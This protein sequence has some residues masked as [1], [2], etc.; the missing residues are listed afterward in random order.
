MNRKYLRLGKSTISILL[1]VI[2]VL[3]TVF[4]GSSVTI[5]TQDSAALNEVQASGL[6]GFENIRIKGSGVKSLDGTGG[7]WEEHALTYD[8]TNSLFYTKV[9]MT[10][11]EQFGVMIGNSYYGRS[12]YTA[13]ANNQKFTISTGSGMNI[14]FGSPTGVYGV[15]VTDSYQL[16][17]FY[18]GDDV[19]DQTFGVGSTNF[20][21][22]ESK[23]TSSG[24]NT[25][26]S[27][28]FEAVS[29]TDCKVDAYIENGAKFKLYAPKSDGTL[30]AGCYNS[31]NYN[32]INIS[33]DTNYSFDSYEAGYGVFQGNSG[34]YTV[35]YN[36]KNYNLYITSATPY[37]ITKNATG[38]GTVSVDSTAYRHK[39]VT[40]TST[41]TNSEYAA[42]VTVNK[43]GDANT[44][45][46]STTTESGGVYTTTFEMPAYAVTVNVTFVEPEKHDL[47]LSK[48]GSGT[49]TG[50]P[51]VSQTEGTAITVTSTPSDSSQIAVVEVYK[52]GDSTTKVAATTKKRS[53]SY[54][55]KFNMPAYDVTVSVTFKT[56]A[57]YTVT[58]TSSNASVGTATPDTSTVTEGNSIVLTASVTNL[59][60][61]FSGWTTTASASDYTIVSGS[62]SNSS[63][64]ILTIIPKKTV[65]FKANFDQKG[66]NSTS[67]K[68]KYGDQSVDNYSNFNHEVDVVSDGSV[69]YCTIDTTSFSRNANY[70]FALTKK[71]N[72]STPIRLKS[73]GGVTTVTEGSGLSATQKEI[74]IGDPAYV[75]AGCSFAS[76]VTS[77]MITVATDGGWYKFTSNTGSSTTPT[78]GE[79]EV[80]VIAK[81]GTVRSGFEKFVQMADTTILSADSDAVYTWREYSDRATSAYIAKD[82]EV[83]VQTTISG[84][85]TMSVKPNA[86]ASAQNVQYRNLYYVKAFVAN[87]VTYPATETSSGS[88]I[89]TATIQL[90]DDGKD[91]E[92][93][94]VY[95]YKKFDENFDILRFEVESFNDAKAAWGDTIACYVYYHNNLSANDSLAFDNV[96][97]PTMGGFPGQPMVYENGTY[98][99]EFPRYD[100]KGHI[101]AGMTLNNYDWDEVN[102]YVNGYN[103]VSKQEEANHQTYD[104]DDF[105]ILAQDTNVDTIYFRFKYRTAVYQNDSNNDKFD[106]SGGY[107]KGSSGKN[108]ADITANEGYANGWEVYRDHD[109]NIVDIFNNKLSVTSVTDGNCFYAVS[110]GYVN[111]GYIGNFATEWSI[112]DKNGNFV[113][114]LAPSV[115]FY[116]FTKNSN[117]TYNVANHTGKAPSSM[118]SDFPGTSSDNYWT[119]Y[120]TLFESGAIG[121]PLKITFESAIYA[122]STVNTDPAERCDGRWFAS[123][124]NDTVQSSIRIE[125]RDSASSSTWT[126]DTLTLVS[127]NTY[128]GSTTKADVAFSDSTLTSTL[129]SDIATTSAYTRSSSTDLGFTADTMGDIIDVNYVYKFDGFYRLIDGKYTKL[130][131]TSASGTETGSVDRLTGYNIVARYT[132]VAN[133]TLTISHNLLSNAP[134][135]NPVDNNGTAI[136]V[137]N[138]NGT[139]T[140]SATILTNTGAEVGSDFLF[141]STYGDGTTGG[142][143][144]DSNT[145]LGIKNWY[146]GYKIK[147]TL[148]T[149]PSNSNHTFTGLYDRYVDTENSNTVN[150]YPSSENTT[151]I[152]GLG[153]TT[154]QAS[155]VTPNI[156]TYTLPIS[157]L[158]NTDGT[159]L[160]CYDYKLFSNLSFSKN[161]TLEFKFYDRESV[162][163]ET[164]TISQSATTLTYTLNGVTNYDSLKSKIVAAVST[165]GSLNEGELFAGDIKNLLDTYEIWPSQTMAENNFGSQ[166]YHIMQDGS[167]VT[168]TYSAVNDFDS[169]KYYHTT[170]CS[171]L[172][173]TTDEK[174]VTYYNGNN[175]VELDS[176]ADYTN[177]DD[178]VDPD[179][180]T[181]VVVWA[182]NKPNRY[183]VTAY[184]PKQSSNKVLGEFDNTKMTTITQTAEGSGLYYFSSAT[185]QYEAFYNQRIGA[186]DEQGSYVSESNGSVGYLDSYL[187]QGG[188]TTAAAYTGEVLDA[189]VTATVS[190]T[191]YVFDGWYTPTVDGDYVKVSSD[192]VYGNR[193]T[194]TLTLYAMYRVKGVAKGITNGDVGVG[195][196][197]TKNGNE[198]GGSSLDVYF[199]ED[200][201]THVQTKKVRFNTQLNVYYDGKTIDHDQK[202]EQVAVVYVNAASSQINETSGTLTSDAKNEIFNTWLK[203]YQS[204]ETYDGGNSTL[205]DKGPSNRKNGKHTFSDGTKDNIIVDSFTTSEATLTSK[206]RAQFVLQMSESAMT[207]NYDNL[208]AIVAIKYDGEWLISD[209]YISFIPD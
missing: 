153:T 89:Y 19:S 136:T 118:P 83:V 4:T 103:T 101:V 104:Y 102:A 149:T 171:A 141:D 47:T 96:E 166:P 130:D 129:D 14:T 54:I 60:Y 160:K 35:H 106:R 128:V 140:V 76:G 132:K 122:K 109:E 133:S 29:D 206:N 74:N 48:T 67:Y 112:Y 138:G 73:V 24:E 94:P 152:I 3:S 87:G 162:N 204:G 195:C 50:I 84:T 131:S 124:S 137:G 99:I 163:N 30:M 208:V 45:V 90:P 34:Y 81:D 36:P 202:I 116:D 82:A 164:A 154:Q 187:G 168:T 25:T 146:P 5:D 181:K 175:E 38:S 178:N 159:T 10:Q 148:T 42:T 203:A 177:N 115:L 77:V 167:I 194:S 55:T 142:I 192:R 93:T 27:F 95:F 111:R 78:K 66:H 209:N 186:S 43:T 105:S 86:T 65:S 20:Y 71:N 11:G 135:N 85:G 183:K 15:Y 205:L 21:T 70:Y 188:S 33:T 150:Y 98:I 92:I 110:D 184:T 125:Y 51:Y 79:N 169:R 18:L 61:Y 40:V 199:V 144:I 180:I 56:P 117:F 31:T 173:N 53:G 44:T 16:R 190:E 145:L 123:R 201:T 58:A 62:L 69:Y 197:T 32:D 185:V 121:T 126:Q 57:T 189:P 161:I 88:G 127:G 172:G 1:S 191:D 120:K 17:F 119:E 75:Y 80:K 28:K 63:S 7:T 8:S 64:P 198:K 134:E 52:K 23:T 139:T 108:Y 12:G 176:N 6:T 170:W 179:S 196:S 200:S 39:V 193:V 157:D 46:T 72:D 143:Q 91:M 113:T 9:I 158:F 147:I 155:G 156:V 13:Y 37:A 100:H 97:K 182:F 26:S 41:P 151:P 59:G 22:N 49:V 114:K 2:M 68:I 207:T 107:Q 165:E 174:W